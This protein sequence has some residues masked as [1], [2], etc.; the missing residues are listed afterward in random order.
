MKPQYFGKDIIFLREDEVFVDCGAYNGDSALAFIHALEERGISTYREIISFEPDFQNFTELCD[1]NLV[2]HRCINK[3][4]SDRRETVLFSMSSDGTSSNISEVGTDQIETDTIDAVLEGSLATFIKMDVEGAELAS[5]KGAKETIQKHKPKLAI[6]IYH[7]R[8]D[9]WQI[10][11]YIHELVPDYRFYVRAH[12]KAAI[13]LVLY[14]V[15]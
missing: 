5:L 11:E 12:H 3:G 6:C 4:T 1:R 7:K 15:Q 10:P 14:A 9:L 8:D 2:N 13:E